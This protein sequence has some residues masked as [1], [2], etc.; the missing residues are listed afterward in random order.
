MKK[1]LLSIVLIA[2]MLV[3]LLANTAFAEK[4]KDIVILYENDVHCELDGYSVL[5]ALKNELKNDHEYVGVVSSGD[6][7][8]GGS[9]GSV[10]KGEY[11]VR[12]MNLVGYDAIA[13]GNHEFDYGID[14]LHEL[15]EMLKPAPVCAN[16][17]NKDGED[18]F[19]PYTMV[20]YG[21]VK[22]AYVGVT[23][24]LT[25]EL[26]SFPSSFFDDNG[27]P[28]YTFCDDELAEVVQEN[29][30][31]AR[32]EGADFV[33]ALSHLGDKS[34]KYTAPEIFSKTVGIDVVLD[35]HSHSVIE[36]STLTDKNG[37]K[38]V[39]SSTG[40][41]FEYIGKLVIS[42]NEITTELISLE[43]YKKTD[44]TVD[45]CI[46]TIKE[47]YAEIGNKKLA[48][49]DF[50]LIT[51]DADGNRII[52]FEETN[53]GNFVSDAFRCILDADIG[54]MNGGAIRASIKAGDITFDS[55]LNVMPYNNTG[56]VVEIS[57]K[58]VLEMLETAM[59][60]WPEEIGRFPQ[61]SGVTFSV[62]TLG[63]KNDRVY[64]VKVKN[65]ETGV[66]EPLKLD[67]N[68][69]VAASNYV[70]LEL[71]DGMALF[72]GAKV[73]SDTGILDVEILE[74]YVVENLGGVVSEEYSK[75]AQRIR[76]TEGEIYTT[77]NN[78]VVWIVVSACV[79]LAI[80]AV[81]V[82]II[83]KKQKNS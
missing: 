61:I 43:N 35:A 55:L 41:Q 81:T 70:L 24:P 30:D 32:A 1:R 29:V 63:E 36:S 42:G 82:L 40:T 13:L 83:R 77:N 34:P 19:T 37:N 20:S 11:I 16:F 49:T 5:S 31:K 14:R 71:G 67:K 48:Y 18:C 12:V 8:Q 79:L 10:S 74:K 3:C 51:H 21:D 62:N 7:L 72:E 6:F 59:N 76:F 44:P 17:K 22:I 64:D 46:K 45:E 2:T 53:L 50:D 66:Y 26:S 57:G 69:S 25:V 4:S 9:F 52:R 33:I 65:R 60:E 75:P 54:Y 15:S 58:K 68:Y 78:V 28:I 47:E 56:V 38:I 80:V 27:S 39:Y 73:I 23:T